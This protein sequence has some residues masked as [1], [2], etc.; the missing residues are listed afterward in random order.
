[1]QQKTL[2]QFID[3]VAYEAGIDGQVTTTGRHSFANLT[4]LFNET[5]DSLLALAALNGQTEATA[6]TN[7]AGTAVPAALNNEDFS[8][9]PWPA[10]AIDIL[11]VDVFTGSSQ[12]GWIDLDPIKFAN[13]RSVKLQ[14]GRLGFWA[15]KKLPIEAGAGVTAGEI[16]LFDSRVLAGML[17]KIYFREAWLPISSANTTF[18]ILGYPD[19][20]QWAQNAMVQII[21]KRDTNKKDTFQA[22]TLLKNEAE[23]RIRDSAKR[24]QLAGPTVPM[25]RDGMEL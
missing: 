9:V 23:A 2:Q 7:E 4:N 13:R 3:R 25:R 24:R 6:V 10:T 18:T 8:I 5:W 16:A 19:W 14:Q 15:I 11:G 20:F 21:T 22:A 12:E 1:M 17:H